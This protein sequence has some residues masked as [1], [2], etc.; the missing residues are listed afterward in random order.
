MPYR[1]LCNDVKREGAKPCPDLV[2]G[3]F[4]YMPFHN[5]RY[6]IYLVLVAVIQRRLAM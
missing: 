2:S 4:C 6:G 5:I 3:L 1:M